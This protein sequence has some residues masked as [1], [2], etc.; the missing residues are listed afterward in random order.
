MIE[1]LI[2][3]QVDFLQERFVIVLV[4]EKEPVSERRE[5]VWHL[6]LQ[7]WMWRVVVVVAAVILGTPFYFLKSSLTTKTSVTKYQKISL[8]MMASPDHLLLCI[9]FSEC[10]FASLINLCFKFVFQAK[11][12]M[13]YHDTT[14]SGLSP[15]EPGSR[16][17]ICT[18]PAT[19]EIN[20]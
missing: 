8:V 18:L 15:V 13:T 2:C 20:I 10:L 1:I 7:M 5:R 9:F 17:R 11:T 3:N 19:W 4:T 16:T 12:N 6:N 14:H